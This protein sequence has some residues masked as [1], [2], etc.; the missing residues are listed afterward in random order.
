MSPSLSIGGAEN[1]TIL[2]VD[3]EEA[4]RQLI[5]L[6]LRQGGYKVLEAEDCDS[7][8]RVYRRHQKEIDLLV[9][10][11]TLPGRNGCELAA[12]L[13]NNCPDLRVLF[14]SGLPWDEVSQHGVPKEGWGFLQKPFGIKDLLTG[15][16]SFMPAPA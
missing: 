10:D 12:L 3:D 2:V 11:I 15:V 7:A 6:I 5:C 4:A 13:R 9:T 1:R 16:Q 14:M 8:A